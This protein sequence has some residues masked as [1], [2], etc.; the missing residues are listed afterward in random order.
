MEKIEINEENYMEY[1][2][3][4]NSKMG[5]PKKHLILWAIGIAILVLATA[6]GIMVGA[7]LIEEVVWGIIG[8]FFPIKATS[9]ILI[10]ELIRWMSF[11]AFSMGSAFLGLKAVLSITMGYIPMKMFQKKHPDFDINIDATEVEKELEKYYQLSKLP[12]DIVKQKEEHL[13]N[14][15]ESMR[16]ISV[17]ERLELLKREKEFWEQVAIQEKY[18]GTGEETI[19]QTSTKKEE[20]VYHI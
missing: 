8:K 20:K 18:Q 9:N 16:E 5:L 6:I 11:S 3:F 17:E 13:E 7:V 19:G 4:L 15:G 10:P 1:Q 14:Y 12:K 2:D